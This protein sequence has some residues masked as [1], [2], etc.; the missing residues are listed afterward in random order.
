MKD[1]G[2]KVQPASCAH[3]KWKD[4]WH[5]STR[6]PVLA[7][8]FPHCVHLAP[9]HTPALAAYELFFFFCFFPRTCSYKHTE[10][11]ENHVLPSLVASLFS[12][13]YSLHFLLGLCYLRAVPTWREDKALFLHPILQPPST[14]RYRWAR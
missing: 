2:K 7:P 5:F 9:G 11:A 1:L 6:Q 4:C 13:T 3:T 8:G 12:E 10:K 14:P